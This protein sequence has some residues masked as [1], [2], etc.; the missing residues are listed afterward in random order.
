MSRRKENCVKGALAL[1]RKAI[2]MYLIDQAR[3]L[4]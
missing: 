4:A 1:G 3:V 2:M